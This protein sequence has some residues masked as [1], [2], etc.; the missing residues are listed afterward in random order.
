MEWDTL[1]GEIGGVEM[2]ALVARWKARLRENGESR[3]NPDL[4]ITRDG[5]ISSWVIFAGLGDG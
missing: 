3:Y 1:F 2:L 5:P 4:P